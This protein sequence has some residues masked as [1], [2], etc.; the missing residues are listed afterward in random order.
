[1]AINLFRSLLA[2]LTGAVASVR[3]RLPRAQLAR[4]AAEVDGMRGR[5]RLRERDLAGARSRTHELEAILD[6]MA[7][8]VLALDARLRIRLANPSAER[9]FSQGREGETA[10]LKGRDFLE[11]T[12]SIE[13][14]TAVEECLSTGTERRTEI[15][16]Y[17]GSERWF[18]ALAAPL[19]LPGDAAL[20]LPSGEPAA[21]ILPAPDAAASAANRKAISGVVLVL[22]DITEL[23]RLERVR[24]DFV[25]NVSHELR[26]PIQL[27]KGFAEAIREEDSAAPGGAPLREGVAGGIVQEAPGGR[28]NRFL[29]II[30]RNADR[31]ESLIQDLLT[32][33]RLEQEGSLWLA[34]EETDILPVLS[35]ACETM[36]LKAAAKSIA[37]DIRCPAGLRFRANAG[38]LEQAV[39]NLVDNAVKYSPQGSRVEIA[40]RLEGTEDSNAAAD[41]PIFLALSVRDSGPGIPAKDLPRL[42]ERFY[43]VDKARSRE[44]GGTGLGLAIVRHIALA[45]GGEVSVESW[46][47]EGSVF[48][49]RIPFIAAPGTA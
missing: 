29:E 5:E 48:T 20:S 45:H 47:G 23:R 24:R 15:A 7:E 22:N 18:Q 28:R 49:I 11:A 14:Q 13:L 16:L 30:E 27:I 9:L 41:G 25:A 40:A 21:S 1:M 4:L 2:P 42:F 33:A 35:E 46:E 34:L 19:S 31:M 43:R 17:R 26:T 10:P 44:L 38:L 6:A 37:L 36:A 3:A 8:A 32:L 12:R 39:L